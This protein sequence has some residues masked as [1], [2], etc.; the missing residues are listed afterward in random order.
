MEQL[1]LATKIADLLKEK[2]ALKCP[3]CNSE[4]VA[5]FDS[6]FARSLNGKNALPCALIVCQD[7]GFVREHAIDSLGIKV[8]RNASADV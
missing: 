5:V 2:H 4:N 7:C 3:V 6:I 1:K 8:E